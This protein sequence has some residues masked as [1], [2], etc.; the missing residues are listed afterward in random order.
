MENYLEHKDYFGTVEFS[1]KDNCL[2][3][4]IIGINDLVSYEAQS[5]EELKMVFEESVE[6]YLNTCEELNKPLWI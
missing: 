4:K 6:D 2:Y 1:S 5:I 3:G